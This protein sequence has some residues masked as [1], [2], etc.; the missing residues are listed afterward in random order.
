MFFYIIII[1]T[2]IILFFLKTGLSTVHPSPS[3]AMSDSEDM[4]EFASIVERIERGEV[5]LPADDLWRL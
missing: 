4:T 1:I 5:S 3:V 2:I